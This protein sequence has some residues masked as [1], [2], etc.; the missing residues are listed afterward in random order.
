MYKKGHVGL[1]MLIFSFLFIPF[2]VTIYTLTFV[3]FSVAFSPIP[4]L[5]HKWHI[6]HRAYTH[7]IGFGMLF[8][9]FMGVPLGYLMN[10]YFGTLVFLAVLAGIMSHLLGDIIVGLRYNGK[11]WKIK[12]FRPISDV[13]IGYGIFKSSN[14]KVNE[15]FL[16][17][18]SI[19]FFV[20][21][22]IGFI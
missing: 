11:P 5:D 9:L 7:N 1:S 10:F 8:G 2:G 20:N 3:S 22:F 17:A 12:P 15:I 14:K 4:D 19:V 16:K 18:G 21:L 13:E 6:K